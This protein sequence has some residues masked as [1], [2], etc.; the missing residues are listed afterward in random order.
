M[1]DQANSKVL[2]KPSRVGMLNLCNFGYLD[3]ACGGDW[4]RRGVCGLQELSQRKRCNDGA[5]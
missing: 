5:E 2:Q 1:M 3:G 4:R